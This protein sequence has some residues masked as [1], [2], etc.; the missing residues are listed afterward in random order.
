MSIL[1]TLAVCGFAIL[2]SATLCAQEAKILEERHVESVARIFMHTTTSFSLLVP[3]GEVTWKLIDASNCVTSTTRNCDAIV[4]IT[5][6]PEGKPMW[7]R[8]I[9]FREP[10]RWA[11]TDRAE[12]HIHTL[13][14]IEGG[15]WR[16]SS[17]KSTSYGTTNVIE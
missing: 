8:V 11:A 6:V 7:Y 17:G 10:G 15:G 16:R 12:F 5:D 9:R 3:D 1:K 2:P 13:S 14:D 4:F